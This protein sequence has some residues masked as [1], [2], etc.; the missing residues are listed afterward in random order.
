[1]KKTAARRGAPGLLASL[2][3]ATGSVIVGAQQTTFWA[4]KPVEVPGYTSPQRPHVKLADVKARHRGQQE[5]RELVVDDG[6]LQAEYVSSAAG[7]SV[8]KRFHPDSRVWWVVI[9]GHMRVDIEGQAPI[10]ATKGSLVQVPKHTLYSFETVGD[11]PTLRFVVS[12]SGAKTIYP[13]DVQPP[14]VAGTK[15]VSVTFN[16]RP[17]G[18]EDG[19]VPHINLYEA[20]KAP[21]YT[22]GI[23][24]RDDRAYT[25]MIYGY[26]KNLPPLDPADRGHY[27]AESP[28]FWLIMAG[29]IRYAFEN[30]EPFVADE[31]DVAYV[32]S[33]TFHLARFHGPG[34]SCRLAITRFLNNTQLVERQ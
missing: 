15:W 30:Q 19:N 5:W 17:A 11:G 8:P 7:S 10:T 2:M 6:H 25:A 32:P 28:E 27:H 29:Q 34:P 26:E 18:Y 33:S 4:P 1:M 3:F 16:R 24:I 12:L 21:K 9:D 14:T 13:K 22:G 20:A 23:V 31:G